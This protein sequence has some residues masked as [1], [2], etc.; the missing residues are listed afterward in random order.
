VL[1]RAIVRALPE[2]EV[3]V[4]VLL[5]FPPESTPDSVTRGRLTL[6][7]SELIV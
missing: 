4:M 5:E 2:V 7:E 1:E 6:A 3:K